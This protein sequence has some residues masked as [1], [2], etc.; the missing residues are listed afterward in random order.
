MLHQWIRLIYSDNGTLIDRSLDNQDEVITVPMQMVATEDY[1]YIGQHFPFNNFFVQID[2]AN[3]NASVLSVQYWT[4][5]QN[6]WRTAVDVLDGTSSS[7]ATLAKS[8]VVQFSPDED[9]TWYRVDDTNE[10][11]AE[12]LLNA[13]KIYNMYWLRLKVSANLSAGTDLKRL[14]YA[15]TRTQQINNLD[16]SI[17]EFLTSFGAT[18]TNWDDEIVT[19]S[20]QVVNDLRR[21]NLIRHQGEILRFDDVSMATDYRVLA[22]I[23]SNLGP[24]YRDKKFDAMAEYEKMISLSNFSFD[25][26][27]DARL[28]RDEI[29]SR[30]IKLVR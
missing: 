13:T 5:K 10:Q 1:L 12:F 2:T 4:G 28:S 26:S 11:A 24:A 14:A 3:S 7:G 21:K 18:K 29:A 20:I 8:G 17:D 22:L 16:V 27:E 15:F 19:A 25:Q 23:Y 30:G 6:S 9:Y